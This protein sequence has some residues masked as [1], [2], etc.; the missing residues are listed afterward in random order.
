[1]FQDDIKSIDDSSHG[2]F[3]KL[4]SSPIPKQEYQAYSGNNISTW[5]V[6][7]DFYPDPWWDFFKV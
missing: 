1:M 7:S 4:G 3:A 6:S 2:S 5:S